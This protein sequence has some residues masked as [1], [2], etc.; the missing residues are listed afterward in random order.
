MAFTERVRGA[1]NHGGG[2]G[3]GL[4]GPA[5]GPLVGWTSMGKAPVG[6]PGG[7][8]PESSQVLAIWVPILEADELYIF[9]P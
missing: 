5:L 1:S 7:R 6:G 2:G 8:A 9:E 3:V 4:Q